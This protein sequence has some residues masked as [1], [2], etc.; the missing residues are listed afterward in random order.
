MFL[1]DAK[2][3]AVNICRKLQPYCQENRINIAGSIRRKKPDPN[4]IE[5]LCLPLVKEETDLFGNITGRQRLPQF[6]GLVNKLGKVVKGSAADGKMMQ[7]EL[8]ENIM[9]DLFMPDEADYF[10]QYAIRTGSANYSHY[11]LASAWVSR[12]WVGS[13][14]GLRRIEDCQGILQPDG[15]RKWKCVNPEAETPPVWQNEA[16]FFAWL[17]LPYVPPE[18]RN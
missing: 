16:G 9:L 14:K 5:I 8:K 15:K 10:R 6:I 11:A 18:L 12:G 7:I 13:D 1:K 17:R 4:D 2:N 3:I